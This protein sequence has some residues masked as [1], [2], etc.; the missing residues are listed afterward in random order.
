MKK[1]TDRKIIIL[2]ILV[3]L[4]LFGYL[5]YRLYNDFFVDKT[6]HKQIDSI[7][8]YG[9]TLSENDTALYK[10]NFKELTTILNEKPVDFKKYAS[11]ISKLFIID[12]YTLSNKLGSTDIGGLQFIHKDL[13][14]NFKENLGSTL[15][16]HIENNLDGNRTQELPTVKEVDVEDVFETKY[17]YNKEE[18]DAYIV[19]LKWTYEKDMG[20]QS[21]MK[22][23]CI[24]VKDVLYIVKGE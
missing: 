15:Y 24:N 20:Y 18:Y 5:G 2:F 3:G 8:F 12:L 9:Y 4:I 7:E 10:D 21:S 11:S 6:V 13:K 16:K 23:T 22:V 1:K 14:D 17:T 19:T